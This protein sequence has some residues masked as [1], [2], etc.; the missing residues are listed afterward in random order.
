MAC[1]TARIVDEEMGFLHCAYLSR[2]KGSVDWQRR[3]YGRLKCVVEIS[4]ACA[5]VV[6]W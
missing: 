1:H 6:F 5:V 2:D 3:L 4:R